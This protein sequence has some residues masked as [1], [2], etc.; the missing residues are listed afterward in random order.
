MPHVMPAGAPKCWGAKY[1]DGE[2]ECVQCRFNDSCRPAMLERVVYPER[3]LPVLQQRPSMY[4]PPP[5][6]PKL[7][8]TTQAMVPLPARPYYPPVVQQQQHYS[9]SAN[10]PP[11][12]QLPQQPVMP[13]PQQVTQQANQYYHQ[14]TGYALPTPHQPNPMMYWHRPGTQSPGYYFTQYP[15]ESVS[16][17]IAKNA[18]L[19][20]MEALMFELMQFFRHWTWPPTGGRR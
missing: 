17:R 16:S 10:P 5:P 12:K 7:P 13:T 1:Q 15:G 20:V 19:R 4:P 18:V 8:Q 9:P 14:A 3:S 6:P 11:A 2:K